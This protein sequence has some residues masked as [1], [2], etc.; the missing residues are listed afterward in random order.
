MKSIA[1]QFLSAVLS[2][3]IGLAPVAHAGSI[4]HKLTLNDVIQSESVEY[5]RYLDQK[6]Y[7]AS[8]A[9]LAAKVSK[10]EVLAAG[11]GI[12]GGLMSDVFQMS[13][14][15]AAAAAAELYKQRQKDKLL[16]NGYKPKFEDVQ[17]GT[18]QAAQDIICGSDPRN[19]IVLGEIGCSGEYWTGIAGGTVLRTGMA[20]ITL[21]LKLFSK[22]AKT[23]TALVRV[24]GTFASSFLMIGGFTASGQLWTQAVHVLGDKQKEERAHNLFGRA[25]IEMA[26]RNWSNYVK[27]EDGQLAA[28]VWNNMRD[29][30]LYDANLRSAW[31]YNAWRF[32]L[33]RGEVVL[34]LGILM[35]ALE[36]GGA[37]GTSAGASVTTA[38]G[39]SGLTASATSL[40]IA[41][42]VASAFGAGISAAVVYA[43]D[44]GVGPKIT[45]MI[46]NT[47]A[48]V[49]QTQH[50]LTQIHL[51]AASDA[52]DVNRFD[53]PLGQR[54]RKIYEKRARTLFAQLR[55]ERVDIMNIYL[56]KYYELR[57]A[58]EKSE[59]TLAMAKE[60]IQHTE[61]RKNLIVKG[62]N[63]YMSYDD[64]WVANCKVPSRDYSCDVPAAQQLKAIDES[65]K[66]VADGRLLMEEIAEQMISIYDK[67]SNFLQSLLDKT[68][69]QFP[70]DDAIAMKDEADNMGMIAEKLIFFMGALHPRVAAAHA[71]R[72]ESDAEKAITRSKAL[73]FVNAHYVPGMD[74]NEFLGPYRLVN[75]QRQ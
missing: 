69:L 68:N 24:V 52:L 73:N 34:N 12:L 63:E 32:G 54:Y 20:G 9:E 28:Q 3:A 58:V 6:K 38:L 50:T 59:A 31:V 39:L 61:L 8:P 1:R 43:P 45:T 14:I 46:Q 2:A 44:W 33:A 15:M 30:L 35:A 60:V 37:L 70:A 71:L 65:K 4:A 22:G 21:L 11:K 7:G 29:I 27:T 10:A 16:L 64:A 74:E 41:F 55:S 53:T 18:I 19:A 36:V 51:L 23:Q 17:A 49:S 5:L 42:V 56:E 67:D 57:E 47:R 75:G 25:V 40:I 13:L 66:I 26:N 62:E 48:F 72:F